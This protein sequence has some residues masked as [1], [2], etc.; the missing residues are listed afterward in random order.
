MRTILSLLAALL[1][2]L[3]ATAQ[4]GF[5]R[6]PPVDSGGAPA[7][8]GLMDVVGGVTPDIYLPL[9]P[10]TAGDTSAV[11]RVRRS[12]DSTELDIGCV[13]T[14]LDTASIATFCGVGDGFVVK[15]YDKSGNG[16]D[17]STATAAEQPKIYISGAMVTNTT[18]KPAIF[19]Y[20]TGQ[21]LTNNP[22]WTIQTNV[23]ILSTTA[24]NWSLSQDRCYISS[25]N[26]ASSSGVV[27][28][29]ERDFELSANRVIIVT[30]SGY[31]RAGA[32]A[33]KPWIPVP[34]TN[35]FMQIDTIMSTAHVDLYVNSTNAVA[36]TNAT[37]MVA[38]IGNFFMYRTG[39]N[40]NIWDGYDQ[41]L[42]LWSNNTNAL[43]DTFRATMRTNMNN[44][45]G[46]Y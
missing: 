38:G 46:N 32:F 35:K 31:G 4:V 9:R 22:G 19:C 44:Y 42:V 8:Q 24:R 15:R 23:F 3:D 18:G 21:R 40:D 33:G 13:G 1:L 43:T 6:A 30:G 14:N 27:L 20:N 5:F 10:A 17:V 28:F 41:E 2:T 45:Y 12:S 7:Y 26:Y 39:G 34:A 36:T 16:R 25:S 11:I 37:L 29:P